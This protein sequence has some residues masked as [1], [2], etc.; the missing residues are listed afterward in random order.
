MT[1][2]KTWLIT[3]SAHGL[4][5]NIARAALE[6]GHN[7][8]A[9]ARRPEQL[10][11]LVEAFGDR[12]K[13]F[14]LDV[15]DETQARA[16]VDFAIESFGRLDVLVNNAGFGH[17]APFEQADPGIF[18]AQIETNFFGVVY[19]MRAALP[20]MR[21]QRAGHIFNISSMGGRLT[22]PG[23][24]AY[25]AS[26]WAVSGFSE[27]VASEVREFGI[28]CV[29]IEPGGMRTEW[30]QIAGSSTPELMEDYAPGMQ[31]LEEML[32]AVAGNEVGDPDKIAAVLVDLSNRADLPAH[33]LLGSD[34][35][36]LVTS[37]EE[38]RLKVDAE[39]EAVS[40]STDF[41]DA[42]LSFLERLQ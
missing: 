3:G 11:P 28:N 10:Q 33:L 7:V 19:L 24:V 41:A 15:S 25:H 36:E 42:D 37:T 30:A 21:R 18:R 38:N 16:A 27:A 39:W 5:L 14:Q 4:G 31:N 12:V 34:A 13:P 1:S 2:N 20:L 9:T 23:M 32:Q 26:K 40:R 6:A 22:I 8:V 17:F 29:A 35:F